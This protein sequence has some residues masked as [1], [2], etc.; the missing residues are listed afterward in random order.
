MAGPARAGAMIYAKDI[1]RLADFYGALVAMTPIHQTTELVVLESA[2]FQ[3]VV[4]A[5]AE[6]FAANLVIS[7]PPEL[8]QSAIRL[9]FTVPS[10]A[11]A[12]RHAADQG[13]S[14]GEELWQGPGFVMANA[15]DPEGNPFQLREPSL[16]PAA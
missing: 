12:R 6:Q 4:H 16:P 8:R 3:L 15:V 13:G 11:T 2:D 7:S 14:V 9:F 10:L 1:Q 5:M